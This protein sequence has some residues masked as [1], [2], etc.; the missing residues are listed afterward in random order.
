MTATRS[1]TTGN[2]CTICCTDMACR[3]GNTG[4]ICP[5]WTPLLFSVSPRAFQCIGTSAC[6]SILEAIKIMPQTGLKGLMWSICSAQYALRSYLYLLLHTVVAAP[7]AVWLGPGRG[8]NLPLHYTNRSMT[9]IRITIR[10]HGMP[11][12]LHMG[13]LELVAM[14]FYIMV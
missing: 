2:H 11:W 5:E 14:A 8:S 4:G 12:N 13:H 1:T 9:R 10:V 3:L 7:A 6:H